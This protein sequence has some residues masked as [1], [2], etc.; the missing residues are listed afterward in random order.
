MI[1]PYVLG[2]INLVDQCKKISID[3][4]INKANKLNK[5]NFI[6]SEVESFGQKVNLTTSKTRFNG[7]RLW[8]ACPLCNRRINNLYKHPIRPLSD[9]GSA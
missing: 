6:Y 1:N 4:L 7:K 9:A 5:I 2:E 3:S 8:F